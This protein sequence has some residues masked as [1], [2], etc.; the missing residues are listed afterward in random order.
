MIKR[1]SE[2]ELE[3]LQK[4]DCYPCVIVMDRYQGTYSGGLWIAF[5]KYPNSLPDAI[6]GDDGDE[7]RFYANH[8][9]VR[10]FPIGRG[11]S[12]ESAYN[13]LVTKAIVYWENQKK[14]LT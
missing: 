12:P 13:D 10:D 11:N 2:V 6:G 5:Q 9:D 14:Q 1:I 7:A 3:F 8:D 4:G